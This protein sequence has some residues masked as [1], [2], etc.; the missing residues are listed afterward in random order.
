MCR[1]TCVL[2]GG[3]PSEVGGAR[4]LARGPGWFTLACGYEWQLP[5]TQPSEPDLGTGQHW[6]WASA[7]LGL[8]QSGEESLLWISRPSFQLWAL[9]SEVVWS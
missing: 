7:A 3:L 2:S 6:A 9:V 5:E 8:G 1:W 4:D